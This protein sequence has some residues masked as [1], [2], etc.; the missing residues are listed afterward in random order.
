MTK[1]YKNN[2][3]TAWAWHLQLVSDLKNIED[4]WEQ[5]AE[6]NI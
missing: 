5:D 3:L 2:I 6:G 1:T 4:V